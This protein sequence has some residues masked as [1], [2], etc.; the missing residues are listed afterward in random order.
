MEKKIIVTKRF[1]NNSFRVYQY[2]LKEFST[3]TA[4]RFLTRLE[5]RIEFIVRN[6]EAGKASLKKENVRSILFTPHNQIFYRCLKNTI[7][8]LCLF[9]MRKSPKKRPY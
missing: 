7:E 8:I 2:L 5:K 9:D 3:N 1:H 4:N 6:P